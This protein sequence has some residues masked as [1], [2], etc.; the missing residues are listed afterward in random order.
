[1]SKIGVR[2]LLCV[3]VALLLIPL[4]V[5]G[6]SG[7]TTT[8]ST[9]AVESGATTTA[10]V[11]TADTTGGGTGGDTTSTVAVQGDTTTTG[12]VIELPTTTSVSETTTTTA[13]ALSS[14]E[15]KLAN[16]HIKAMGYIDKVWVSG[17]K[18]YIRIDYAQML[19]GTA[20]RNA[21]IAD[22]VIGP[23]DQ[24]D[25]DYYIQNTSKTK[26][27]FEVSATVKITTSTRWVGGTEKM[28]TPCTWNAF[29]SFWG[30]QAGLNDSEKGLHTR[31]WWIER[32]GTVAVKIDEQYLP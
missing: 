30:S 18:R 11:A 26:R 8:T 17:G 28:N 25:T 23:G 31:P 21:A 12:I 32:D 20:A 6:C 7:K 24:L 3:P 22:G 2:T 27:T 29:K 4:F 13:G 5:V 1:M 14:A 9:S 16:G 10:S 15:T 19:T